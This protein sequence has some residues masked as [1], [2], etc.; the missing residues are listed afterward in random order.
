MTDLLHPFRTI[1]ALLAAALFVVS[2][3]SCALA[4]AFPGT[5][6]ACCES[7]VPA[8]ATDHP[9]PGHGAD[10]PPCTTLESGAPISAVAP[11]LLATVTWLE[12]ATLGELLRLQAQAAEQ[13]PPQIDETPPRV[14][15]PSWRDFGIKALPVRGP[16]LA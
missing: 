13:A 9:E 5:V 3:N 15:P 6:D 10:C 11:L 16:S 12:D 14:P 8:P 7:D 2:T 4:S 1:L